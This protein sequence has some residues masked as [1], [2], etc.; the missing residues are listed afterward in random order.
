[1]TM[2]RLDRCLPALLAASTL[3]LACVA[4]AETELAATTKVESQNERPRIGLVLGGGGARGAAHIGVLRELERMRIPIDAIAGTSMGAMVGGLYASGASTTE[5]V[6]MAGSID[7][8][9]ELADKARRS[10]LNFRR[11]EDD[12]QF[13]I[14]VEIGLRDGEI[15]MP[16]GLVQ[17]HRLELLLHELTI[18]VSHISDFDDLPIPFRAVATDIDE[19]EAYVIDHG[20]LADAMRASMSVP[21]IFAPSTIDD[22]L[23]V[24]GGIVANLPVDV[25]RQMG[26]DVIIAVDAEFPLYPPE[27]LDSAVKVSE[28]VLTILIH[29]ETRRQ[30]DLLD[31]NDIL[32]RPDL[33]MFASSDFGGILD[34]IEPGADATVAVAEGLRQ[35]AVD[36]ETY[37]EYSARRTADARLP[38]RLDFVRIVHDGT[39]SDATLAAR[40]YVKEGDPIDTERLAAD[41][42][43]LYGLN[44]Y[45]EVSYRLVEEEGRQGVEYRAT[46]KG[47]GS[48]DLLFGLSLEEGLDGTTAFN[49][50]ARMTRVGLNSRGAEWRTDLQLGTEPVLFSEFYQPL[51]AGSPWFLAPQ[52][53]LRRSNLGVFVS[54]D[55]IARLRISEAQAGLDFG[56]EIG[57]TGEFR[58][59]VYRGTGES[60]V[61][62]GDPSLPKTDFDAGGLFAQLR[63]DTLDDAHFPERGIRAELRWQRSQAGLGA[64]NEFD[65]FAGDFLSTWT[66]GRNSMQ[67]GLGYA[68]T[69]NGTSALQDLFALGGF[70]R[71]SGLERDAISGPHAALAKLVYRRRVGESA[72]IFD[73]P[74]YL[75]VTVEAGNVWQSRADIGFDSALVNGSIF[76]GFDT[77]F[78]PLFLATGIAE[79]GDR[80]FYLLLGAPPR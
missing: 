32:I 22:R 79:G 70:Q 10:D 68:T 42:D 67:V 59:G 60:T 44:L 35:L 72:G 71:L 51:T 37:A 36:E 21:G 13:P 27:E 26:V 7:W 64:D 53:E 29:K 77:Y 20:D 62:V 38:K 2:H 41:A 12:G 15:A 4:V 43:R 55:E 58:L 56:R 78:G 65:T 6:E 47:W 54:Q 50:N 75:G 1:M 46:T 8:I 48:N 5:L 49:L 34:V 39:L 61:K 57:Y 9:N 66:R 73:V 30:I 31:D 76:A 28:Q 17:G 33:G 23:L 52:V 80:S 18:A 3:L 11:K 24:D 16:M 19:A 63:F 14:N 69:R 45:E 25:M 74:I 40:V